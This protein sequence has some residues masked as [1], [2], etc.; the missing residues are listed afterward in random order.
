MGPIDTDNR[1]ALKKCAQVRSATLENVEI[2]RRV[3]VVD[4]HGPCKGVYR[5]LLRKASSGNCLLKWNILS[6]MCFNMRYN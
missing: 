3:V 5:A 1:T 6:Y 2:R 4:A